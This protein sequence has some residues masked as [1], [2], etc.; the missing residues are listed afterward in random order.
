MEAGSLILIVVI[1]V[2][3]AAWL[4]LPFIRRGGATASLPDTER[5]TLVNDYARV[6]A[7]L[8]DLEEDHNTGKIDDEAYELEKSRL[9]ERG[10]VLLGQLDKEGLLPASRRSEATPGA[11]A[12]TAAAADQALDE[13]LE[14]AIARYASAKAKG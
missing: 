12:G 6:V 14:A 1:A 7:L 8:R 13:A 10:V 3:G 5:N 11:A 9:S 4:A 2:L